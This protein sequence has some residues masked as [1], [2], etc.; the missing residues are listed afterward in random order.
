[1]NTVE[2]SVKVAPFMQFY[3]FVRGLWDEPIETYKQL[4]ISG[5]VPRSLWFM[6][7]G[8]MAVITIISMISAAIFL[9]LWLISGGQGKFNFTGFPPLAV[10]F[11]IYIPAFL[12]SVYLIFILLA[13]LASALCNFISDQTGCMKTGFMLFCYMWGFYIMLLGIP[14][15]GIFM[16]FYAQARHTYTIARLAFQLGHEKAA[17]VMVL[18]VGCTTAPLF[19]L[20]ILRHFN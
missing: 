7:L 17:L 20:R 12:I 18:V 4:L 3:R 13:F 19:L 14:F 8:E 2:T 16:A 10:L 9:L 11:G 1:M 5:S 15:C 6:A